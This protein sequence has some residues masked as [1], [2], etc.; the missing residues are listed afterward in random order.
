MKMHATT[1][2]RLAVIPI[3]A[4]EEIRREQFEA[5]IRDQEQATE[6]LRRFHMTYNAPRRT[7]ALPV[8][9]EDIYG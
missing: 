4:P 9:P 7:K 3:P 8:L 1:S 5:L 2:R 6:N